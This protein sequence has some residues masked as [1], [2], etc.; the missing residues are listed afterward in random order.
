MVARTATSSAE[1]CFNKSERA[2]G[3]PQASPTR[4]LIGHAVL[5]GTFSLFSTEPRKIET[6][7]RVHWLPD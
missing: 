6:V 5:H 4:Y 2:A 1:D 7:S 3:S